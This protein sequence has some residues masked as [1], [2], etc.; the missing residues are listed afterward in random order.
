VYDEYLLTVNSSPNFDSDAYLAKLYQSSAKCIYKD[1]YTEHPYLFESFWDP[2]DNIHSS[3]KCDHQASS[4]SD[5]RGSPALGVTSGQHTGPVNSDPSDT[6][7]FVPTPL[8]ES[9]VVPAQPP[10]TLSQNRD[11]MPLTPA[12]SLHVATLSHATSDPQEGRAAIVAA[13]SL[14]R[15]QYDY[16]DNSN[17]YKS[18]KRHRGINGSILLLVSKVDPPSQYMAP[19]SDDLPSLLNPPDPSLFAF[20]VADNKADTLTQSQ[21]LKV[22]DAP[23]FIDSQ[24]KEIKGLLDMG[25]F[26]F[27]P[28][29][30]KPR[31]ACLLSSI[32]SYHRKRSP[33]CEI[34][35][36]KSRICVDG[37]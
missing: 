30:S 28:M 4:S 8:Q 21:M 15:P 11:I 23:R 1:P 12:A 33:V 13:P 20:P 18:Y 37:S 25:V 16:F 9:S 31:E 6:S 3:R 24:P 27:H 2:P 22:P 7:A 32:W 35:K 14:A 36:Y 10:I 5:L 34:L 17:Y 19:T 29:S 26:E